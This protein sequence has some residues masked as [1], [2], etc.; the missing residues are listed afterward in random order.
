MRRTLPCLGLVLLLAAC[1]S[2]KGFSTR[3]VS[4]DDYGQ[5]W[6]LTVKQGVLAC[7]PGDVATLTVSGRSYDLDSVSTGQNVPLGLRR[8]WAHDP[9][10]GSRITLEP[11]ATDA[12][13]LCD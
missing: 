10:G 2:D 12:R 6:P 11:L 3:E 9:D 1:S 8:I 7:E 5:K 13:A 4:H